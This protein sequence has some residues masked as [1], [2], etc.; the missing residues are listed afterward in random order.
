M[1]AHATWEATKQA[2][3][4]EFVRAYRVL[5]EARDSQLMGTPRSMAL[6]LWG[7]QEIDDFID[8]PLPDNA[9]GDYTGEAEG[10]AEDG[11]GRDVRPDRVALRRAFK[12]ML[13]AYDI[14]DVVDIT[15]PYDTFLEV[16]RDLPHY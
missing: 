5:E 3:R 12:E 6:F 14:N 9:T 10:S 16:L 7:L 2:A 15:D 13:E 1:D 8:E 11:V 4:E